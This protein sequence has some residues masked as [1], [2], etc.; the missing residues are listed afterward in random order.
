MN[1][2]DIVV[3]ILRLCPTPSESFNVHIRLYT[4]IS[5]TKSYLNPN[6]KPNRAARFALFGV[7]EG[8]SRLRVRGTPGPW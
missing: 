7:A 4:Y 2:A 5:N 8:P 3:L 1:G 6:A